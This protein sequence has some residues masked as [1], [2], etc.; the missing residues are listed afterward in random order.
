MLNAGDVYA[1][2]VGASDPLGGAIAS[3]MVAITPSG[4][5]VLV[6]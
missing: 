5:E 1:L 6:R 2:H 3:A 4:C